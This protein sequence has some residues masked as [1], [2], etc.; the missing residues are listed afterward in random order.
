V[1]RRVLSAQR[2]PNPRSCP[3]PQFRTKVAEHGNDVAPQYVGTHRVFK[4]RDQRTTVLARHGRWE[5][6]DKVNEKSVQFASAAYSPLTRHMP[7]NR[8]KRTASCNANGKDAEPPR[9]SLRLRVS[10]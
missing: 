7:P 6:V 10:A 3:F 5:Q 4:D 9:T 2:N 8:T 1:E